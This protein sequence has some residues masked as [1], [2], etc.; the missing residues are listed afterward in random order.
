VIALS[1]TVSEPGALTGRLEAPLAFPESPELAYPQESLH[2][3]PC[4][5]A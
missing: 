4:G 5:Y 1:G 2:N 3:N